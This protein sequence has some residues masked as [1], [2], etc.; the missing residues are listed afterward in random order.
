MALT[1]R[2]SDDEQRSLATHAERSGMS[3]NEVL[4]AALRDYIERQSRAELLAEVMDSELPPY[5][6]ALERLGQ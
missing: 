6:E 1:L 5:A 2:L 3:Q 4:R